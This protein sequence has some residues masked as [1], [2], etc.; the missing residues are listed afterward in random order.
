MLI[1]IGSSQESSDIV[2]L[3]LACHERIRFFINLACRLGEAHDTPAD[4]IQDAATRVI[5]Y[6]SESL[7]LHVA[8]EEESIVPRLSGREAGLDATLDTM[9]RE[10][11]EHAPQLESL[12][13]ICRILQGSPE[14]LADLRKTLLSA[15]SALERDFAAH[16]QEEEKVVLPAIKSLL[17]DEERQSMLD[18]LRARRST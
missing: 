7:P 8:D 6:F 11:Q 5:R 4:E 10:H 12:L 16:L 14:R 3:L 15:A 1:K 18:E 2:G 17:T 13:K 9:R